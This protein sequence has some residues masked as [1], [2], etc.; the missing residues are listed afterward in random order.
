MISSQNKTCTSETATEVNEESS[1]SE[2]M[3]MGSCQNGFCY[4][5]CNKPL[6]AWIQGKME[7]WTWH[8]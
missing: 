1:H 2:V 5:T 6:L 7:K 4:F 8:G 3:G